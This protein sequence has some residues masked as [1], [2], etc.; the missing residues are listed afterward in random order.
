[1]E[2]LLWRRESELS[3]RIRVDM[4]QGFARQLLFPA[5][6]HFMEQHP[7][8]TLEIGST[9]RKVDIVVKAWMR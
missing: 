7:Q 3:G 4:S 2:E 1:M 8:L 5:L 6:Q 9:D